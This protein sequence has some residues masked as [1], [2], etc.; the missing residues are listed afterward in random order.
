MVHLNGNIPNI[1]FGMTIG[2][3]ALMI[4]SMA[5]GGYYIM[6]TKEQADN[7]AK[8]AAAN[9]KVVDYINKTTSQF[10]ENWQKRIHISNNVNNLTQYKLLNLA[11]NQ[12]NLT[13]L[14]YQQEQQLIDLA[15]NQSLILD[16]QI[17]NEENIIGNLSH[18]RIIANI[19]YDQLQEQHRQIMKALNM[20]VSDNKQNQTKIELNELAE[21]LQNITNRTQHD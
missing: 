1:Q 2:V 18:H 15:R 19:T 4:F 12:S 9:V 13:A 16:K 21:L 8:L 5:V 17:S 7:A 10:I 3:I 6:Q 20:T 11:H 14:Q